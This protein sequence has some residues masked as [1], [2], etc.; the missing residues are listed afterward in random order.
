MRLVPSVLK[1]VAT[2]YLDGTVAPVLPTTRPR[3]AESLHGKRKRESP[4][5]SSSDDGDRL[6]FFGMDMNYSD[7]EATDRLGFAQKC[8]I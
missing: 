4:W 5:H 6:W 2:I 1:V 8:A 3:V 7:L